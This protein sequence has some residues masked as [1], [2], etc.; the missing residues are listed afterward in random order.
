MS[1]T[2]LHFGAPGS[3]FSP[4]HTVFIGPRELLSNKSVKGGI[5]DVVP[6]SVKATAAVVEDGREKFAKTWDGDRSYT[7]AE[8]D[9][10]T[11]RNLGTVRSDLIQALVQKHVPSKDDGEQLDRS[12]RDS[13]WSDAF[14]PV[15]LNVLLTGK[16]QVFAA[17]RYV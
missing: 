14:V 4:K 1:S 17:A 5:A 12:A 13:C 7:F 16:D 9:T 15:Q 3:Q 10:K 2:T 6:E 8:L 11:S